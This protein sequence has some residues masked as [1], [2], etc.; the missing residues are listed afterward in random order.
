MSNQSLARVIHLGRWIP[1]GAH[2][3]ALN[4]MC[5]DFLRRERIGLN[6][7]GHEHYVACGCRWNGLFTER[8]RYCK[9]HPRRGWES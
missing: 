7:R 5:H 6:G 4:V 2:L 1:C 8:T 3:H 9:K